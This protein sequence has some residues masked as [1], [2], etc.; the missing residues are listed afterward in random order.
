MTNFAFDFYEFQKKEMTG[1]LLK[2]LF[3]VVLPDAKLESF[4]VETGSESW[5]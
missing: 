4:E 2:S 5:K 3:P 1:Y